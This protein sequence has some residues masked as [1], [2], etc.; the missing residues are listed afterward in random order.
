MRFSMVEGT[1][2]PPNPPL[3]IATSALLRA[4]NPTLLSSLSDQWRVC[5][6]PWLAA[7]ETER[8][9][10]DNASGHQANQDALLKACSLRS[11]G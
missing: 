1:R 11:I 6:G 5:H 10:P 8:S 3:G 4:L 7:S 9:G 2:A